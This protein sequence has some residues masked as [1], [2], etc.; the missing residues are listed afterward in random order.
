MRKTSQKLRGYGASR[1]RQ[2]INVDKRIAVLAPSKL[3]IPQT[4]RRIKIDFPVR[5]ISAQNVLRADKLTKR[6]GTREIFSHISFQVERGQRLVVIGLNG[7]GKTTLLRALLGMT[8]LN[9]G[10]VTI[11][12]RVR[13]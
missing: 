11:G 12:D 4:S 10:K 8:P 3:H 2:R 1:V 13:L 6:Y 7:A 5:S 9:G